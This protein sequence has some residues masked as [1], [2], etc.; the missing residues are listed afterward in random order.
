MKDVSVACIQT[1]GDVATPQFVDAVLSGRAERIELAVLPELANVPYFPLETNSQDAASSVALDGPE[2]AAFGKVALRHRCYLMLGVY[3]ADGGQQF[4]AAVLLGPDGSVV[5]GRTQ[6]GTPVSSYR[7]V[8]LCDVNLPSAVF[9]ESAYFT[10]GED[11]VV[12]DLPF[13]TV[14]GLICYDRHFPEAWITLR[15][16]GAEIVCVCTTS[17]L[18]ASAYFV[19]EIQAMAA[20]QSVYAACANRVGHQVLRTSKRESEFLGA[21]LIAGPGGEIV[22]AAPP[23]APVAMIHAMLRAKTLDDIRFAHQFHEHRRPSTYIVHNVERVEVPGSN[24]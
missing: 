20:Q 5:A 14:G 3:L 13:G 7:K 23:R 15:E 8:H 12:W 4:N 22:A 24:G 9:C 17:P 2:I 21:S 16:M 19:P 11:H 1:I 10:A 6:Q 18:S